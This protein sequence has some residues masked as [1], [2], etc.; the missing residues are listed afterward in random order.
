MILIPIC[1]ILRFNTQTPKTELTFFFQTFSHLISVVASVAAKPEGENTPHIA[2]NKNT[3]HIAR[4]KN[5]P[6]IAHNTVHNMA[7]GGM[8]VEPR[9]I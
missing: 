8:R 7:K 4:N 5:T 1:F 6:H 2:R 9:P 3:P